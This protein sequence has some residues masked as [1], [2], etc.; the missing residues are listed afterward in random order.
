[1]VVTKED[2]L[3]SRSFGGDKLVV[4]F[5]IENWVNEDAFFLGLDIVRED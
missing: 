2:I 1:M 4:C 3:E 5:N